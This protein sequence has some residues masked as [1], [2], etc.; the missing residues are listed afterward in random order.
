MF[1]SPNVETLVNSKL[2]H[3][4][5][6]ALPD[7]LFYGPLDSKTDGETLYGGYII[8]N[9]RYK[10]QDPL[11]K[12]SAKVVLVHELAHLIMRF[13]GNSYN[14]MKTSPANKIKNQIPGGGSTYDPKPKNEI[15]KYIETKVFGFIVK[16]INKATIEFLNDR[17]SWRKNLGEFNQRFTMCIKKVTEEKVLLKRFK[18]EEKSPINN[19]RNC[20]YRHLGF[21]KEE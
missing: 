7:R 9:N 10:D 6:L 5:L 14:F 4:A 13:E 21:F 19:T 2:S 20:V 3:Q 18:Y 16:Y 12:A 17:Q 15:G 11:S 1:Y 8:L